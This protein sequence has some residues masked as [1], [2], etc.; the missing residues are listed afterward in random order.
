LA[1]AARAQVTTPVGGGSSQGQS[2]EDAEVLAQAFLLY[3][4]DHY[5]ASLWAYNGT[6]GVGYS[7]N[8]V[9]DGNLFI[10]NM[11]INNTNIPLP[12]PMGGIPVP[13]SGFQNVN[14]QISAVDK[15]GNTAS[16]GSLYTNYLAQGSL[17]SL[18]M[19]PQ[20]PPVAIQLPKGLDQ[21]S[22]SVI[23]ANV[24]GGW[25]WS[26]DPSTGLLTI[27]VFDPS[28]TDVSYTVTGANGG[29]LAHGSLPFFQPTPGAGTDTNSVFDLHNDGNVVMLPLGQNGYNYINNLHFDSMVERRNQYIQAKVIGVPDVGNQK[30]CIYCYN[31]GN[32]TIE[33]RKWTVSGAMSIVPCT[34]TTDAYGDTTV[35]TTG[36]VDRAV[37]TILP[38]KNTGNVVSVYLNRSY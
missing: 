19:T 27:Q 9:L 15:Y 28:T 3:D 31:L 33:V 30:L 26:Y 23:L 34:V 8:M 1:S 21:G 20:F 24:G 10:T 13:A 22:L 29:L 16:Q 14:V 35:V 37:V 25:G 7:M 17:L 5:V 38:A 12:Q 32:G 11:W 6:T 4:T 36:Y 2:Y 18:S